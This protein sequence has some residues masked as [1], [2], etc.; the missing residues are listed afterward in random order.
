MQNW[1]GKGAVLAIT[2]LIAQSVQ[3]QDVNV[4]AQDAPLQIEATS[5]IGKIQGQELL[6]RSSQAPQTRVESTQTHVVR[7][8]DTLWDLSQY[9]FRD[10]YLWPALWSFNPQVSNPHWIYPGDVIFLSAQ[11]EAASTVSK[12]QDTVAPQA[13]PISRQSAHSTHVVPGIYVVDLPKERGHILFSEAEKH[14]LSVGDEVQIDWVEEGA[15][16]HFIVGSLFTIF[17]QAKPV[18]DENGDPLGHK[19]LRLGELVI[20]DHPAKGLTTAKITHAVRE[21]ERGDMILAG[22]VGSFALKPTVS[23]VNAEGRVIDSFDTISQIGEEQYVVI[24]R[25]AKDGVALGN[26]WIVFEQREGLERLERGKAK[27]S[28]YANP[29]DDPKH[30]SR[31]EK[32]DPRDGKLVRPDER[33]WPLGRETRAPEFPKRA[34]LQGVYKDRDYTST[35][36][37]LRK[38]GEITVIGVEDAFCTA[39]V[40]DARREIALDDR[41]VL[42]RNF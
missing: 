22:A 27:P 32:E 31:S 8:G 36:L 16:K 12:A 35:D 42:L 37:P 25:G 10:A 30:Q 28:Q 24:N 14:L 4:A 17:S 34:A 41:V 33:R 7:D 39:I 26:R 20:V 23:S 6:G 11:T 19:L 38:I 1:M 3:A 13:Q 18:R 21:I 5:K 9:Y 15:R 40:T 2:I 29:E